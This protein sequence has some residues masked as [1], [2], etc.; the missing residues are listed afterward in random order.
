MSGITEINCIVPTAIIADYQSEHDVKC[1]T[2]QYTHM[3][4]HTTST[5]AHEKLICLLER[6]VLL[7]LYN[8][9]NIYT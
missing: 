6:T 3:H 8:A 1:L 4:I 2:K 9:I 7:C 5:H